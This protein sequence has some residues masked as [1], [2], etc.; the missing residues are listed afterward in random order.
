MPLRSGHCLHCRCLFVFNPRLKNQRYCGRRE[1]QRTRRRLW[2]RQ[3]MA[4]DADYQM[5]QKAAQ[6]NWQQAHPYYWRQYRQRHPDYADKN[7]RLQS[8]RDQR[9]KLLAKMDPL[10]SINPVKAGTYYLLP[11]SVD[12]AKMDALAQKITL[13]P[14]PYR[15]SA[16]SCKQGRDCLPGP[17]AR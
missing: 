12:L 8:K 16:V 10:D 1:C 7:R 14:E 11:G 3:K 15:F 5:N 9:R 4:T 13:I 2:Q 6:K 17:A